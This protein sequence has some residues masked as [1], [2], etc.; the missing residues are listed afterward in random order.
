MA[1]TLV[2]S[3][4]LSFLLLACE[5]GGGGGQDVV[6][7]TDVAADL[8]A[9]GPAYLLALPDDGRLYAAAGATLITPDE[10]NHP[11][12][13]YLGGTGMNRVS[14]GVHTD[15]EAR[16]LLLGQGETYVVLASLD[17]VGWEAPDT[18]RVAARLAP[19]G[20]APERLVLSSTHTH[21]A[22]DT[23]G[24]WGPEDLVTGRCPAYHEWLAETVAGLV[25]DLADELVPVTLQAAE[26]RVAVPES[27]FPNLVNDWRPPFVNN[28]HFTVARLFDDA[29][30]TVATL[31][32]WHTHPEAMIHEDV[33][34]ADFPHWTRRAVEE[35]LGGT[36]LYFTGTVGGLQTCMSV[37]VPAYDEQG[38]PLVEDG[39]PALVEPD[40]ADKERALGLFVAD[41]ALAT[42][43]EAPVIEGALS[44]EVARLEIPFEN[45]MMIV[46]VQSGVIEGYDGIVTDDPA[47]CGVF[48]CMPWELHHLRYGRFHLVDL[49]GELFP[50]SS[51][52]R[53]ASQ[54]DFSQEGDGSW[55]VYEYPAMV[56]YRAALP[57]GHLLMELGLSNQELGYLVPDSDFLPSSHPGNYEEYFCVSRK[58]EALVREAVRSILTG[59]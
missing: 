6:S 37:H 45:M 27:N 21:N 35:A 49:P 54:Y 42:L 20:I 36:C 1:R 59:P 5:A 48:G 58:A 28:D 39:A 12:V 3:M 17:L 38:A 43:A 13:D 57:E 46:G 10:A 40:G 44:L 25:L 29:D 11:C 24:V 53:P 41:L 51:V 26:G 16:V 33:V 9:P 52:G 15:L 47:R 2:L 30:A 56:G 8:V 14:E 19:E 23:I 34:T 55:G 50:E 4:G 31:V 32:N 22:P 18:Q 7:G